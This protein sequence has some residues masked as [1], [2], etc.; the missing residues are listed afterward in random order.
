LLVRPRH[1]SRWSKWRNPLPLP[2]TPSR[3]QDQPQRGMLTERQS[4]PHPRSFTAQRCEPKWHDGERCCTQDQP[5]R[6]LLRSPGLA[7]TWMETLSQH[8]QGPQCPTLRVNAASP[9]G[10]KGARCYKHPPAAGAITSRK[11]SCC[12]APSS[13]KRLLGEGPAAARQVDGAPARSSN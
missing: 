9:S 13:V 10:T 6:G 8:H 11:R 4:A 7:L 1:A 5:Q 12:C 2:R 3:A